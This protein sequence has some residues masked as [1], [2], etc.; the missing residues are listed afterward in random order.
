MQEAAFAGRAARDRWGEALR[1]HAGALNRDLFDD[2]PRIF[3]LAP[4]SSPAGDA[5]SA[6][7]L[8]VSVNTRPPASW[9]T[10]P[11]F[12]SP[13]RSAA[14]RLRDAGPALLTQATY[15]LLLLGLLIGGFAR[16]AVGEPSVGVFLD[17][18]VDRIL[19]HFDK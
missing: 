17:R 10:L 15:T 11:A 13:T 9:E 6:R 12:T 18:V 5:G 2:R 1:A 16:W 8:T 14:E 7:R 4:L 3:V 19:P